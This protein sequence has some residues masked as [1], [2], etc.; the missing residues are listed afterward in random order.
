[1]KIGILDAAT[2][3]AD[4][5]LSP[6]KKCGELIIYEL[7]APEE[8]VERVKDLDVIITNK[9]VLG[10]ENLKEC[11]HLK[12]IALLATG[13]NNIDIQYAK[14]KGIAVAN[15]AGYSTESVAQHT[16]AML[17]HLI[18]H[19]GQYD[20]YVKSR[21]YADSEMFTYIAWPYHELN[22]KVLG[23]V[24]LGAIGRAVARIATAFGMEVVYYSTS[25]K[26]NSDDYK[27]V[28][29]EELLKISDVVS[30]HAPYNEQTHHLIGYEQIV[31]MKR[32][33]YL[34]NLGRGN[35]IVEADLARALNEE[36]I[37]GAGLDVLGKEPID[38]HNALFEV[39]DKNRLLITPHIA[40]A[41]V[42]AR[43]QLIQEVVMN[44]EALK[45]QEN[46]NRIV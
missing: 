41:S 43:N 29:L 5:D 18:E 8:I 7:T 37:L 16:F 12:M 44:I 10:E 22:G 17:L 28:S 24:G 31:Q 6:L 33:A 20:E 1:M 40:W 14:S 42:E 15:V 25:G 35:I 9:V 19:L 38:H 3:G 26:N 13:Y 34:L 30:V 46:R 2:V 27:R 45:R 21:Q 32:N 39:K 11:T 23:I 36:L 4:L